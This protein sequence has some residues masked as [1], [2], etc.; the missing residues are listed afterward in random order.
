V[1]GERAECVETLRFE[2]VNDRAIKSLKATIEQTR[3][4]STYRVHHRAAVEDFRKGRAFPLDDA[5]HIHSP[6]GRLGMNTGIG[7]AINLAWKVRAALVSHAPNSLLESYEIERIAFA[8]RLVRTTGQAFTI[9]TA[10]GELA[11]LVRLRVAPF[12]PAALRFL[13]NQVCSTR[14]RRSWSRARLAGSNSRAS[15]ELCF[16]RSRR[17]WSNVRSQESIR[18]QG[19]LASRV[20]VLDQY[21]R[22]VSKPTLP[23]TRRRG[24]RA[25]REVSA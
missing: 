5:A 21:G 22:A 9:A 8:R 23:P 12:V 4:F 24:P 10:Q 19:S 15:W 7:D 11:N 14:R 1:R 2:D 25:C 20:R 18:E 6:A 13:A 3:W 17:R 16:A